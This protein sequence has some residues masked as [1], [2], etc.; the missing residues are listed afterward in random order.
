MNIS[1]L[2]VVGLKIIFLFRYFNRSDPGEDNSVYSIGKMGTIF[3]VK[4]G[5]APWRRFFNNCDSL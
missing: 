5:D 3:P 1:I 2:N 4:S